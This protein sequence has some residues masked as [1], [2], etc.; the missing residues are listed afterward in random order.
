MAQTDV[1][2]FCPHCINTLIRTEK[3]KEKYKQ[4]EKDLTR[5]E[6]ELQKEKC[7]RLERE[8]REIRESPSIKKC[9]GSHEKVN[10]MNIVSP[11]SPF[12]HCRQCFHSYNEKKNQDN[13]DPEIICTKC[14]VKT[15][16]KGDLCSGCY[17]DIKSNNKRQKI[18]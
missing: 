8:L 11:H 18:K 3:D 14:N 10:C 7:Q 1:P 13:G 6:L 16:S 12:K 9:I 4:S 2:E 17:Y 15:H 5:L